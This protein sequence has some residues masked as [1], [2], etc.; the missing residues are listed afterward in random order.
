MQTKGYTPGPWLV[1]QGN[2][3]ALLIGPRHARV[4]KALTGA[5]LPTEANARLIAA[6][7]DLL[8]A[9]QDA[10]AELSPLMQAYRTEHYEAICGK[11]RAAIAKGEVA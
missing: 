3:G 5:G 10:L 6:A 1:A 7:P 11:A 2:S 8:E 4:A 9:L